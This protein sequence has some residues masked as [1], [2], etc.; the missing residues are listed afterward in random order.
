M[1]L[2]P[3]LIMAGGT[4]GHV[5]PA[6]A[7]A[8]YLREHGV[9]LFWLGTHSGLESRVVP[10]KG[11]TL[12]TID[13]AGVR[14]KGWWSW[15]M[16]PLRL[17]LA[18]VQSLRLLKRCRPMAVLGM[19]GFVSAPGGIAAWILGVPL[20][21][22]EQNAIAGL[23]NRLLSRL[24]RLVMQG[25]PGTFTDGPGIRTTGNPVRADIGRLAPPGERFAARDSDTQALHLLVLGGSQGSRA[26]NTVVPGALAKLSG[27]IG[28]EVLHQAGPRHLDDAREGYRRAAI[29]GARV[30]PYIEDM[31]GAYEWADLVVCRAGALT[32]AELC[33]VGVA[34]IL[35]PYPF[36]VDD[37][38][39]ANARRLADAGGALLFQEAGL[40]ENVLAQHLEELASDRARLL[41][42]ARKSRS[43]GRPEAT[44]MVADACLEVAG[45]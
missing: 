33:V 27:T 35:V 43:L 40:D 44:R 24:A 17:L 18:V 8:D 2:N 23:S 38:Q 28:I 1:A 11:Y 4:G 16:A 34:A 29:G 32:I 13:I 14:G 26:L 15:L 36:A 10:E 12:L 7:V 39:T 31:A 30:V 42:M 9:S 20:L 3:I 6:L 5:Y 22:H 21:I 45:A 41:D 37:H 25:F 19:G